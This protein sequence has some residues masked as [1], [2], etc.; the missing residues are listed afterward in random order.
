MRCKVNLSTNQIGDTSFPPSSWFFCH[1]ASSLVRMWVTWRYLQQ[2][3]SGTPLSPSQER[4]RESWGGGRERERNGGGAWYTIPHLS[5]LVTDIL[6]SLRC[7]GD[8]GRDYTEGGKSRWSKWATREIS[9]NWIKVHI[10]VCSIAVFLLA[11]ID[12][13]DSFQWVKKMKKRA[14]G[15]SFEAADYRL[16]RG[17]LHRTIMLCDSTPWELDQH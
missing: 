3:G 17:C 9:P 13:L 12:P 5:E 2:S 7:Y 16:D 14:T 10:H 4:E 6:L 8:G 15:H 11:L 1:A